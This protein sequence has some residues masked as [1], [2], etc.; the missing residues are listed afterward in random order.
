MKGEVLF[1]HSSISELPKTTNDT[2][3]ETISQLALIDIGTITQIYG[4]G[5]IDV[6]TCTLSGGAP[7]VYHQVEVIGIG[8]PL[9]G[10]V[11]NTGGACLLFVP[12]RCIPNIYN[13]EIDM[14]KRDFAKEGVKALPITTAQNLITRLVFS[15]DGSCSF[16]SDDYV[17]QFEKS[18]ISYNYK[19]ELL[20]N[21]KGNTIGVFRHTDTSGTYTLDINEDGIK[22]VFTN[23]VETS[24]FIQE[25]KD[26][27][28]LVITHVQP[29]SQE[30]TVLNTVTVGA[31]GTLT[32][33][34]KDKV[35]LQI[36]VDGAI[37]LSTDGNVSITTPSFDVN[38]GDLTVV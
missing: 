10:V 13:M 1:A 28:D 18:N 30:D 22:Q 34:V 8:S 21:F 25:Y 27:G 5:R 33:T 4:S 7:I 12:R 26:D 24:R 2:I 16:Q 23:T 15:S 37:S 6:Q 19:D 11:A 20:L 29:G 32:I 31:E 14:T 9:S 38:D 3:K 35:T 36:G 17:L